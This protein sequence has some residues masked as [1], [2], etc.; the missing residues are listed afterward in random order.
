MM[1]VTLVLAAAVLLSSPVPTPPVFVAG[2]YALTFRTPLNTTICALPADWVGSNHGT[3]IFL[4]PPVSCGGVGYPS[5]SRSFSEDV[6]R[7]EVFYAY[8]LGDPGTGP[9]PCHNVVGTVKFIA[10]DRKLCETSEG[11]DLRLSVRARYTADA[12]A[13]VELTLVTTPSRRD[14]DL[15]TFRDLAGSLT[16]CKVLW[17]GSNGKSG[18]YGVGS[19][20]PEEGEFF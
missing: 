20:C 7:I 8:W 12:P 11:Q 13:W 16:Q 5:S 1:P 19:I 10:K 4:R 18:S 9:A 15:K 17:S 14:A 6:P 2:N 3:V